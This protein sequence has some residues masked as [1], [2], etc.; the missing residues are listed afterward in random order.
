KQLN[1]FVTLNASKK[2]AIS[3]E[4]EGTHRTGNLG[5]AAN[6]VTRN[7]NTFKGAEVFEFKLKGGLEYQTLSDEEKANLQ[8][9]EQNNITT[10]SPF[11][12]I[13]YGVEA[14][15]FIPEIL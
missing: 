8:S 2:K 12:T 6:V 11:N 1:C 5:I 9:V 7:K 3:I 4:T 15:F 10:R 14:S 13:E